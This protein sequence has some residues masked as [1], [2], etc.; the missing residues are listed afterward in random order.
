MDIKEKLSGYKSSD[1]KELSEQRSYRENELDGIQNLKTVGDVARFMRKNNVSYLVMDA[2]CVIQS[3]PDTQ[4]SSVSISFNSILASVQKHA[5]QLPQNEPGVWQFDLTLSVYMFPSPADGNSV[6]LFLDRRYDGI[7]RAFAKKIEETIAIG[8]GMIVCGDTDVVSSSGCMFDN[9]AVTP[10]ITFNNPFI[11]S[12][13]HSTVKPSQI[14]SCGIIRAIPQKKLTCVF[15]GADVQSAVSC[16]LQR[17]SIVVF[18]DTSKEDVREE[19][20]RRNATQF[21]CRK[22]RICEF[23]NVPSATKKNF[24]VGSIYHFDGLNL[25]PLFSRD[26]SAS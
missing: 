5:N 15:C 4:L 21:Q 8:G 20:K 14:A 17:D 24:I 6:L 11:R 10:Q 16:L 9:I 12:V 2:S 22:K 23:S 1:I 19:L 13:I 3:F 18:S 25:N 7:D 26:I